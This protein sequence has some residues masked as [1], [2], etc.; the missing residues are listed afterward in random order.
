[1]NDDIPITPTVMIN[2]AVLGVRVRESETTPRLWIADGKTC[3]SRGPSPDESVRN[4]V[5][6]LVAM[7]VAAAYDN[8][9]DELGVELHYTEGAYVAVPKEGSRVPGN[10]TQADTAAQAIARVCDVAVTHAK[11][12]AVGHERFL[13]AVNRNGSEEAAE[14]ETLLA[15]ANVQIQDLFE[16]VAR[17]EG[18]RDRAAAD[19][20]T[21]AATAGEAWNGKPHE[22]RDR[23]EGGQ[24]PLVFLQRCRLRAA[25]LRGGGAKKRGPRDRER[26]VCPGCKQP[27][28]AYLGKDG[29]WWMVPHE[30]RCPYGLG[31]PR[32]DD[33]LNVDDEVA[34]FR[35]AIATAGE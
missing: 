21:E 25:E 11:L 3:S 23:F 24:I 15:E 20:W 14:K 33:A 29:H 6:T 18:E 35:R 22:D 34:A 30:S 2:A 1:M 8:V 28:G 17:L 5:K 4:W 27:H 16:R 32:G 13:A 10:A 9:A 12:D 7:E 19:A 26:I 31:H